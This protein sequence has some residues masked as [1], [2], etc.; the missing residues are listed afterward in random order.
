MGYHGWFDLLLVLEEELQVDL[1]NGLEKTHVGT[2]VQTNLVLPDVDDQNLTGGQRKEGTFALKVLVLTTLS[3]VCTL[4]VH[5]E[6]VLRHWGACACLLLVLGHPDTLG[7]LATLG[8]RHD[9]EVGAKEVVEQG[10][11]SGGL[12]TKDGD[13]VVVETRI[14]DIGYLEIFVDVGAALC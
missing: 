7:S 12:G 11:L 2:L 1:E 9:G 5:D 13:E 6:D 3:T 8:F 4:D 14:G 10:G